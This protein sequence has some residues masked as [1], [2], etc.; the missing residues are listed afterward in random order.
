M[1][2]LW[3]Y[4]V[5][6]C[7]V[8]VIAGGGYFYW[9]TQQKKTPAY[10]LGLINTAMQKH[11]WA[12]FQKHFD[13]K[14][15]YGR[16]FDDVIAPTLQQ[17]NDSTVNA[18]LAGIMTNIKTNFVDTLTAHTKDYVSGSTTA[19]Q[20][21]QPEQV[22]T[23]RFTDL[24]DL[25][26]LSFKKVANSK[27]TDATA[28]IDVTVYDKRLDKEFTLQLLMDRQ[29]DATWTVVGIN[30]LPP[31]LN[32]IKEAQAV[33]L[34]ELNKPLA[35]KIKTD[36][37]VTDANYDLKSR[38]EPWVST[39]FIY[40]P[41]ISFKSKAQITS[42]VGQVQVL[43]EDKKVLYTQKYIVPGPFPSGTTKTYSFS[44]PLNPF[45]Y[46]EKLL[47]S[48]N[49]SQI[50]TKSSIIRVHFED[51]QELNLLEELPQATSK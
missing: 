18:F 25:N 11:N 27:I 12:A 26:N 24:L 44:W 5:A 42:F 23:K 3:K 36:I 9:Q 49:K 4:I 13:S 47:A 6:L 8:L 2:S 16:A 30:N 28:T 35:A 17:A 51:G 50:T 21:N 46:G 1:K 32:E 20:T 40:S 34:I 38:K 10:S 37:E 29:A 7:V 43:N 22:F 19:S 15:V 45:I 31:F 48:L 14:K 39:A 41:T 33:K